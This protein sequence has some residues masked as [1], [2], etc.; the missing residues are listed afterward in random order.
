MVVVSS[1]AIVKALMDRK[2]KIYSSRPP[3]YISHELI[4]Q[5][6]HLLTSTNNDNWRLQRK[7]LHQFFNETLCEKK[8]ITLQNAEAVQMLRD[9]CLVPELMMRHPKRY[10]N[11]II[12]SM[13][14]SSNSLI[15]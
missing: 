10:S 3:S 8:H 15:S 12:T 9:T 7:I 1:P 11:S 2:S 4:T 14:K 5:G 13:G 6:D